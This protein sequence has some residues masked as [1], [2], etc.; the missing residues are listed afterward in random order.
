LK[1]ITIAVTIACFFSV[2]SAQDI[3]VQTGDIIFWRPNVWEPLPE[4]AI[5]ASLTELLC[6]NIDTFWFHADYV[7]NGKNGEIRTSDPKRG[8]KS[9]STIED[10]IQSGYWNKLL[11]LRNPALDIDGANEIADTIDGEY[12]W[13]GY[14]LHVTDLFALDLMNLPFL[15][16][17]KQLFARMLYVYFP[18]LTE[19]RYHCVSCTYTIVGIEDPYTKTTWDL[20]NEITG[21][22]SEWEIVGEYDL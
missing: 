17:S 6:D 4:L 2:A 15:L 3:D 14:Y 22:T 5:N 20:V 21:G 19:G 8:A 11:V 18:E 16:C 13:M 7:R 12:D 10:R 1:R 9:D